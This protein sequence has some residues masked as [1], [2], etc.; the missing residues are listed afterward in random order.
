MSAAERPLRIGVL[1]SQGGFAAHL[2]ILRELGAEAVEVR[3][4][5]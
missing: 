3:T 5:G 1:A 4:A 2:R